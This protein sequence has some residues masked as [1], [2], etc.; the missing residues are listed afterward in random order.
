MSRIEKEKKEREKRNKEL[1]LRMK[2]PSDSLTKCSSADT[3]F[4]PR[5]IIKKDLRALTQLY[6]G[7][8]KQD[9]IEGVED[10]K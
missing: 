6:T 2:D 4:P 9:D 1:L 8:N 5:P 10:E 7:S 3:W